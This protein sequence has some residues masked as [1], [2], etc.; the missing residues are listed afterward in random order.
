MQIEVR[1]LL[2][3]DIPAALRLKELAQWNQTENDWLRLLRLEPNGCFCATFDGEVVATTTTTTYRPELA[4][5]GM[6]L[7]DPERRQL[8]IA[9]KLMNAAL[10]YLAKAGVATVKLDATPAGC[11]L[12]RKLGFKDESLIERWVGI[13]GPR[14]AS[15]SILDTAARGKALIFDLHVFGAERSKLLGMLI[16]DCCVTPLVTTTADGDLT[17]YCLARPGSAAVYA[18]PLLATSADGAATLLDGLFSQVSGQRAYVD[19]NGNFPGGR[20]ILTERGFVKQRDLIRMTYGQAS[21]A[22][23]CSSIF[24]IAGPELG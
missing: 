24:A 11:S 14:K 6:V 19:L 9:T 18:G 20:T 13:A 23:S 10:E 2:E 1:L 16:D 17:G 8:G 5:I 21:D 22:G 15:C 4:W 12:Y 7:V 3:S